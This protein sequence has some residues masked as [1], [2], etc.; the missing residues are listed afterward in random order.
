MEITYIYGKM[1]RLRLPTAVAPLHSQSTEIVEKF[2]NWKSSHK[3]KSC[4]I[5]LTI[6]TNLFISKN[7]YFTLFSRKKLFFFFSL[8]QT[9]KLNLKWLTTRRQP[10]TNWIP[11]AMWTLV[12]SKT[13]LDEILGSKNS[14]DYL[15]VKLK[16]FKRDENKQFRLAQFDN[17]RG[18][19]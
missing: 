3:R 13:D 4:P 8:L 9:T 7:Q 2:H 15:D 6:K 12:I 10:W 1:L 19:V 14:F 11:P 17:G 16:V 5:R 18:R